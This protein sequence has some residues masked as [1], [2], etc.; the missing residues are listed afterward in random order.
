MSARAN[1]V[2]AVIHDLNHSA[3]AVQAALDLWVMDMEAANVETPMLER[4]HLRLQAALDQQKNLLL[5]MRDA[6]LLEGNALVLYPSATDMGTLVQQV[7]QQVMPRYTI[8]ECQLTLIVADNVSLAWC[9]AQ[10][11]RRVVFNV[12]DNALRYTHSF[13]D[14]GQVVVRVLHEQQQAVCVVQ[15]N[16]RGI[17]AD[18]LQRLGTKFTRLAQGEHNTEGMGLGLNF[19]IGILR[20]SNGSLHITSDG[21]GHGTTVTIRLPVAPSQAATKTNGHSADLVA[22]RT[23]RTDEP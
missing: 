10:R 19:C 20:L 15:D 9:D 23:E 22:M 3:Q 7:V 18:D 11:I 6:A 13:R 1:A 2:R 8:A 14:D 16:G 4:G 21:L 5:E 17:A 12:L